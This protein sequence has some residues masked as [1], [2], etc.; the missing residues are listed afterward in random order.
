[1]AAVPA[2]VEVVVCVMVEG[3]CVSTP[4]MAGDLAEVV[5]DGTLTLAR[6]CSCPLYGIVFAATYGLQ[7][8]KPA[9]VVTTIV[10]RGTVSFPDF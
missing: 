9:T 8:M 1:M 4:F 3:N 6:I 7:V 5:K 2:I 10:K